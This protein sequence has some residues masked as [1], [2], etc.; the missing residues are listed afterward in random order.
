MHVE[1][2]LSFDSMDSSLFS[3]FNWLSKAFRT[4]HSFFHH[5]QIAV[6]KYEDPLYHFY[7]TYEEYKSKAYSCNH[8][9]K[10]CH[11]KNKFKQPKAY[12]NEK[13]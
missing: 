8:F 12:K 2:I 11:T 7:V 6:L 9:I 13:L 3:Y 1:V 4:N 5:K 10:N